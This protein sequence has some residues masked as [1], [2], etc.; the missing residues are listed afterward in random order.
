MNELPG[1]QHQPESD[2]APKVTG[3]PIDCP[4]CNN[5]ISDFVQHLG[6]MITCPKCNGVLKAPESRQ[7]VLA[8]QGF[9]LVLT[10]ILVC[11]SVYYWFVA[12]MM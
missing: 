8:I 5:R 3:G 10:V 9:F 12:A 4:Y 1:S 11:V 6:Q 7:D 2:K